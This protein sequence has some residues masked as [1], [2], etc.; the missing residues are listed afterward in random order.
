MPN[1]GNL[2]LLPLHAPDCCF[3]SCKGVALLL[4]YFLN[5]KSYFYNLSSQENGGDSKMQLYLHS[6]SLIVYR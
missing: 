6:Y 2:L 5:Q 1:R 3:S 4:H